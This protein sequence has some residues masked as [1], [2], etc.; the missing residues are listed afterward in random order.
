MMKSRTIRLW[1][2]TSVTLISLV[3]SG[4]L[5][6]LAEAGVLSSVVTVPVVAVFHTINAAQGQVVPAVFIQIERR[7]DQDPLRLV[8]IHRPGMVEATYPAVL[9]SALRN[10]LARLNYDTRGLTVSIGFSNSFRFVGGSLSA[11]VV[12]GT[13][14]A[15]EGRTLTPNLVL[16][17]TVEADGSIGP[18]ADLD[19][20][21]AGAGSYSVLYPSVQVASAPQHLQSRPVRTLQEARLLMLP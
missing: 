12:I 3:V 17:G 14:G 7:E 21:I 18:I 4:L 11:A 19:T 13:V 20:K 5:G 9:E 16:T 6:A 2:Q 8:L 15:L 10:G 1:R